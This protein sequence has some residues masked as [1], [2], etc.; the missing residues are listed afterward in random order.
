[1]YGLACPGYTKEFPTIAELLEDI[2]SSGQDPNYEVTR[3]GVSIGE[4]AFSLMIL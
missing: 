4:L 2:I 1:M 3:N